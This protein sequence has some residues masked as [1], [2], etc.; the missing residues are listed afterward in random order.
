MW[1]CG[2][3]ID[4][5]SLKVL[6]E[7]RE[8]CPQPEGT[9]APPSKAETKAFGNAL[10]NAL[11]SAKQGA[12]ADSVVKC[13][14]DSLTTQPC[15]PN[16]VINATRLAW[17]EVNAHLPDSMNGASIN[18]VKTVRLLIVTAHYHSAST[19]FTIACPSP[20]ILASSR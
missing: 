14:M 2:G 5:D 12:D 15:V 19:T 18:E 7:T 17:D 3:P 6:D 9:I 20:E 10:T 1:K 11:L 4:E 13:V 8:L 16:H